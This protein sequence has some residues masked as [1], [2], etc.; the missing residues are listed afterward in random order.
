TSPVSPGPTDAQAGPPQT[1]DRQAAGPDRVA[2]S[3]CDR[4]PAALC[5][6]TPAALCDRT[7]AALCDRTPAALCDRTP[8]ALCDRTPAALCDRM[9][10]RTPQGVV[11]PMTDP[12]RIRRAMPESLNR[13][14]LHSMT[15]TPLRRP[16]TAPFGYA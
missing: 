10:A 11:G 13:A 7:P 5:D 4:T 8:A 9:T 2:A 3:L 6:R 15:G 1:R 14:R 16:E 12:R